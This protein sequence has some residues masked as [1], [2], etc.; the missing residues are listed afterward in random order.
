MVR[1]NK[2]THGDFQQANILIANGT[3]KVI[4][5]EASE[6]RFYMYDAFILFGRI[7]KGETISDDI[8]NF[9][10]AI[11]PMDYV[12]EVDENTI[13]LLLIEELRF[14]VNETF[15]VNFFESGIQTKNLCKTIIKYIEG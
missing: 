6:K 12:K 1:P 10:E 15:S 7:R 11:E 14:N 4:D 8:L 5:W 2:W 9:R 3:S 13:I